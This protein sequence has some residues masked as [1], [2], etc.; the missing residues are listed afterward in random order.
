M[1]V[2]GADST[3]GEAQRMNPKVKT[4]L[5]AAAGLILATSGVVRMTSFP[6]PGLTG[7]PSPGEVSLEQKLVA[8][9]LEA[10]I[11]Y[12]CEDIGRRT[13]R[14]SVL[15]DRYREWLQFSLKGAGFEVVSEEY[16]VEHL[17]YYNIIGTKV[18]RSA[19]AVVIG[20]HYDSYGKSQCANACATGVATVL[21]AARHLGGEDLSKTLIV[22]LFGTG[23]KPHRG[24]STMGAQIW[25]DG[26]IEKGTQIDVALLVGSFGAYRYGDGTQ[27]SSFPW[28]LMYPGSGEWTGVYGAFTGKQAAVDALKH[29]GQVTDLPARGFAAPSWFPGIPVGDQV[30][31]HS[32]GVPAVLFSDTGG[33]RDAHLRSASDIPYTLNFEQMSRRVEA[34]IEVVKRF[35]DG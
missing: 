16:K 34:Y 20:T 5:Y 13:S 30:A 2:P 35:A 3:I 17:T 32:A 15:D 25:V 1:F 22:G 9:R 26:A 11:L 7:G 19:E 12:Q 6:K 31:F 23:E 10:S 8:Q 28:Y 33:E 21:E 14:Y 24:R 4:A 18:G 29:W 27:N